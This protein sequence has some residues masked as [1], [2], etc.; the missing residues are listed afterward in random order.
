GP[1]SCIDA[2]GSEAH[3]TGLQHFYDRTKQALKLEIDR[4]QVLREDIYACRKGGTISIPG[5]YLGTVDKFPIGLLMN[6][7]LTVKSGQTHMQR[8]MRPL[9]EHIV[10]GRIDPGYIITHRLDTLEEAPEAY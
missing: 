6:K 7:G 9:L 1:D 2:V 4:P 5:V 8:Y 3:G 10:T